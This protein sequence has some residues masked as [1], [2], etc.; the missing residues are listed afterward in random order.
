LEVVMT[1]IVAPEWFIKAL[2]ALRAG[3][4]GRTC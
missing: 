4:P 3:P 2:D 1:T